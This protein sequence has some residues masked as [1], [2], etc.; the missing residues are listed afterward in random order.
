MEENTFRTKSGYCHILPDKIVLTR[1]GVIGKLTELT[2]EN[3]IRRL[4]FRY[5][6]LAAVLLFFAWDNYTK[7]MVWGTLVPA[8]FALGLIYAIINSFN[9]SATPVIE[10]SKIRKVRF[11]G[12]IP[13]ITRA[14]FAVKF[15][16]SEGK[17][18]KRLILLPGSLSGGKAE[19][20]KALHIMKAEGLL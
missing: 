10:R 19:T 20:E 2:A 4:L 15:E 17:I 13:Y 14:G 8:L 11:I 18:K 9:N 16:D 7:G 12:P 5:M 1:D 3:D 6:I